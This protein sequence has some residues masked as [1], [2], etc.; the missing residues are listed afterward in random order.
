MTTPSLPSSPAPIPPSALSVRLSPLAGVVLVLFFVCGLLSCL[1]AV[2]TGRVELIDGRPTWDALRHGE[3]THRIADELANV[4]FPEQAARLER[5]ASWLL[6]EDL[7]PRVRKGCEGWLFIA[8]ELKVHPKADAN[9]ASKAEQ[10]H[11]VRNYLARRGIQL[12]VA[13]VPDKSR[14]AQESLCGIPRPER[15][16][17]RIR[18]WTAQLDGVRT[19]D[20]TPV[21]SV[22]GPEA[23]LRTDT[24][25]SE[26]GA[27][28]AAAAL[29]AAVKQ[30]GVTPSPAKTLVGD[31]GVPQ[32]R[33][34]DL[35]RLAGLDWLP[36]ALQPEQ[37]EVSPTDFESKTE[38]SEAFSEDDLFGDAQLPNIALIGTSFSQNS[39]F[40]SFLEQALGA[41]VGNFAKEGG[42]FAGAA[43]RYFDS[44]D[45]SETPPQ[46]VIWEIPE[47]DIH[48]PPAGA[49]LPE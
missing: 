32:P 25:W 16:E 7:G 26:A 21:L 34:G 14:I 33:P 47:R 30:T 29:A 11:A 23:F 22:L 12:I 2:Y 19:L 44:R 17:A 49:I 45:F 38:A 27:Q 28:A 40:Q 41:G 4:P 6:I 36:P 1:W 18:D 10:V 13:I 37:E 48:T 5:A 35:P 3:V 24:H 9:A 8:D 39:N 46:L 43:T 42:E 20:L 15:F 31:P